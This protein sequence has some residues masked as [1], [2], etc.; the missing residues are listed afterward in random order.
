[1]KIKSEH[2]ETA[3]FESVSD[4]S[5]MCQLKQ[6]IP[7]NQLIN[8]TFTCFLALTTIEITSLQTLQNKLTRIGREMST[9]SEKPKIL[10][11]DTARASLVKV[12]G[13]NE[14]LYWKNIKCWFSGEIS[15]L[16]FDQNAVEL[17]SGRQH[18][19]LHND[20]L[21]A[22]LVKIGHVSVQIPNPRLTSNQ[23]SSISPHHSNS[24]THRKRKHSQIFKATDIL[25][26]LETETSQVSDKFR[27][28]TNSLRYAAKEHFLPDASFL[29][30][31][32]MVAAREAGV[33][34]VDEKVCDMA[35]KAVQ[36]YL[37]NLLS[38]IILK[39]K[40]YRVSGNFFYDVGSE[41]K[42]LEAGNTL[43]R[44]VVDESIVPSIGDCKIKSPLTFL[45]SLENL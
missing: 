11:V 7:F 19:K 32:F 14:Q 3:D 18:I 44:Q 6:P 17:L 28:E 31:R 37:K 41:P 16:D 20:F 12:L 39:K 38:E 25:N 21:I 33:Q 36:V 10:D 40:N 43:S 22:L 29:I 35:A 15:K 4:Q 24:N 26:F 45:A 8:F 27:G 1:M 34:S 30:G 42:D 23:S 13:A 2:Y 9:P 5:Q